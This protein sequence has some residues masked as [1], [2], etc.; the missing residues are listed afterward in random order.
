MEFMIYD[1]VFI[2]NNWVVLDYDTACAPYMHIWLF[3]AI[4]AK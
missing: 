4:E 1:C 2:R 3:M